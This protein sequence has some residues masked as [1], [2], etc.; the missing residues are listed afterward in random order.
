MP[1]RPDIPY[2]KEPKRPQLPRKILQ[3]FNFKPSSLILIFGL[4][5]FSLGIYFTNII[6]FLG[7]I[8][9]FFLTLTFV[10]FLYYDRREQHKINV[11]RKRNYSKKLQ[12]Y[13]DRDRAYQIAFTKFQQKK[14]ESDRLLAQWE[15][16]C[17]VVFAPMQEQ[18]A[19]TVKPG[20]N[21]RPARGQS[22][23]KFE[24]DLKI[25]FPGKIYVGKT[26]HNPKFDRGFSYTADFAYIDENG[27]HIDIE[28]DEPYAF[29]TRQ[30]IHFIDCDRDRNYFFLS[31]GWI[32]IR[33][34]EEQIVRHPG[35]CCRAIA[36][37]IFDIYGRPLPRQYSNIPQLP[38]LSR[39]TREE[40]EKMAREEYRQTYL[41][42]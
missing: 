40:A 38:S 22:E 8:S 36:Q 9:L 6:P 19:K 20:Q 34:C 2:F 18:L 15:N 16:D 24:S 39:W 28:I 4:F 33:F 30:P 32:V 26:L 25:N 7:I 27:L 3:Q 12:Q 29:Q 17:K 14:Q 31:R 37:V 11:A 21:N 41:Q 35:A 42:G 23:K 1:P 10:F 13:Q 5:G